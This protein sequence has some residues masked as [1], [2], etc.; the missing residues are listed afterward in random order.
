MPATPIF[1][2]DITLFEI[3]AMLNAAGLELRPDGRGGLVASSARRASPNAR[4]APARVERTWPPKTE[5][6]A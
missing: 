2:E 4:T 1:F 5:A 3:S 6:S